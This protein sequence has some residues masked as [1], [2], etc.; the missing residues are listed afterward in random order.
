MLIH[1]TQPKMI[2]VLKKPA[3]FIIEFYTLLCVDKVAV[4]EWK[5]ACYYLYVKIKLLHCLHQGKNGRPPCD[6]I[7]F[8]EPPPSPRTHS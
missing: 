7:I 2:P 1:A 8:P 3:E 4:V 5:L 6:P